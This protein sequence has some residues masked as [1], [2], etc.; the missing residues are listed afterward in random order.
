[1]KQITDLK[2]LKDFAM[3]MM[4]KRVKGKIYVNQ[5]NY[6]LEEPI[7]S[8]EDT[9]G[10]QP[11]QVLRILIKTDYESVYY[12]YLFN[13]ALDLEEIN[14]QLDDIYLYFEK[15]IVSVEYMNDLVRIGQ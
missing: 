4:D 7:L 14:V 6:S 15:E 12:E 9:A 10:R 13:E 1:M 2:E 11:L 3:A 5:A 8:D